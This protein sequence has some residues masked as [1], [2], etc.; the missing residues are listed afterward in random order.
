MA[1]YLG[2]IKSEVKFIS[3]VISINYSDKYYLGLREK[4]KG[5]KKMALDIF[6]SLLFDLENRQRTSLPGMNHTQAIQYVNGKITELGG[7]VPK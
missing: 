3:Q 2:A 5:N 4:Y 7:E 6:T 1:Y